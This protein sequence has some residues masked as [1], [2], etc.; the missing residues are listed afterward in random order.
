VLLAAYGLLLLAIGFLGLRETLPPERRSTSGVAGTLR[1]YRALLRDRAYVGLVLVAG[2]TM[3]GLFSY[4][5]GSSFVYQDE[6]GLDEQQFGLL[7]GAGAFWLIGATQLNPV[8]LRWFSP[9]QV[10]VAGTVAGAA[11][12]TVLL[13]LAATGAGGLV[14]VVVPLWAVLFACGLALPN[15][16]ALALS[17][18]GEAAGTAAALLGAVQF[19]VGAAVSPVVGLLGNDA[20][21]MGAVV[22]ASL[23]LAIV[24][25]VVVVRPWQL[26]DPEAAPTAP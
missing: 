19:G 23:V 18:H 5:S 15:A 3:A 13:A 11:A 16:P 24:V 8:L 4:V 26:P 2:L 9:A 1:G 22:V 6:F 12:G 20:V 7:F 25:L 17:R 10:L 14:A 21:A